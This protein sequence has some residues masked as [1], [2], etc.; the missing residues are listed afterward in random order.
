MAATRLWRVLLAA[1]VLV[2]MQSSLLHP[3]QHFHSVFGPSP[4]QNA[5][6]AVGD[7]DPFQALDSKLCELCV[8]GAALGAA[9]SGASNSSERLSSDGFAA[10]RQEPLFLAAFMPL[11]HSQ[12]PPALL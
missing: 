10:S 9:A 8:A 1:A 5:V 7:Q 11:F 2:A 12:A 4:L 6:K 3:F